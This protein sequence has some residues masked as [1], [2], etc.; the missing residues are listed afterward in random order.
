MVDDILLKINIDLNFWNYHYSQSSRIP[1]IYSIHELLNFQICYFGLN[2]YQYLRLYPLL[3]ASF[4]Q[5]ILF[6][7]RLMNINLIVIAVVFI[8]VEFA[9]VFNFIFVWLLLCR[10]RLNLACPD[11]DLVLGVNDRTPNVRINFIL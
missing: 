8:L 2:L 6:K 10:L 9:H 1:A 4:L 11:L 3:L 7:N 5:F